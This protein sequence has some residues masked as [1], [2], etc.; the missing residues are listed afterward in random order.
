MPCWP[1]AARVLRGAALN[2]TALDYQKRSQ[3]RWQARG[4]TRKAMPCACACASSLCRLALPSPDIQ[5]SHA[6]LI[7]SDE[8]HQ[9]EQLAAELGELKRTEQ[10]IRLSN[11]NELVRAEDVAEERARAKQMAEQQTAQVGRTLTHACTRDG[12]SAARFG[13]QRHR[14]VS[15]RSWA[16]FESKRIGIEASA[17][18][19]T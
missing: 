7:A 6:F 15:T 1:F 9:A 8:F 14:L 5:A 17:L 11:A 19:L 16:G 3:R 2:P 10:E 4:V 13:R 18:V 12:E